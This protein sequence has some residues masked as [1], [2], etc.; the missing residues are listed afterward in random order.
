M[1]NDDPAVPKPVS[2]GRFRHEVE[3]ILE[4]WKRGGI[5]PRW[6]LLNTLKELEI[7]RR[8]HFPGERIVPPGFRIFLA[9]VDDGWGHGLQIIEAAARAMGADVRHL[10]L[11]LDAETIAAACTA[12]PPDILGLTVLHPDSEPVL[13]E[14]STSLPAGIRMVAGG[15]AFVLDPDLALRTG[16]HQVVADV[17]AFMELLLS[18]E[19]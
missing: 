9:T 3:R 16:V 1:K 14:I 17:A 13:K 19:R 7:A 10:G 2:G 12:A 4:E 18:Y 5:P 11:L 8:K 15:P 6:E